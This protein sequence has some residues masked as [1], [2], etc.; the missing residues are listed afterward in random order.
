M[1]GLANLSSGASMRFNPASRPRRSFDTAPSGLKTS[2]SSSP[3]HLRQ[4]ELRDERIG[5]PELR[6]FDAIQS[7]VKTSPS[8]SPSHLRQPELR[9]ERISANLSSGAST[10]FHPA[11]RPRRSFDTAPSGLK[12]SPS[13][14][15]SHL[16]Q[17]ELRDERIS[18]NLS[19][20]ASTRFHLASRTFLLT[21][22]ST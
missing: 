7:G 2:P 19:S 11:S 14:S 6:G 1:N 13:S 21:P 9:D 22:S 16:R 8:Y 18:A 12:T 20:G 17:P 10:R 5:Q 3:S 4:P 15:P